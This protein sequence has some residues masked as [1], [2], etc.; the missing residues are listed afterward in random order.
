MAACGTETG[1]LM[2]GMRQHGGGS[3]WAK[4]LKHLRG[5]RRGVCAGG[6]WWP[7]HLPEPFWVCAAY[8]PATGMARWPRVLLE[9]WA[10]GCHMDANLQTGMLQ[11]Y[12]PW[13]LGGMRKGYAQLV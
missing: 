4:L 11:G 5:M 8:A 9:P 12:A 3:Q 13:L 6:F 7:G 1:E 10:Q 2:L